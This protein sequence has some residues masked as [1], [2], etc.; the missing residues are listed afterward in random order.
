[1]QFISNVK[2]VRMDIVKDLKD[3]NNQSLATQAKKGEQFFNMVPGF[4]KAFILMGI[5]MVELSIE[6]DASRNKKGSYDE[7][8]L[9]QSKSKLLKQIDDEKRANLF[10]SRLKKQIEK[11]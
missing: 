8:C 3:F 6:N 7:L 4:K 1:M 10:M 2:T 9:E 5:D 11:H